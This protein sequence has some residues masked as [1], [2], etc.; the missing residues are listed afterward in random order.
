MPKQA[1]KYKLKPK[2][3][4]VYFKTIALAKEYSFEERE[5]IIRRAIYSEES[6]YKG[7]P[8]RFIITEKTMKQVK[9]KFFVK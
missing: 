3:E 4:K 8:F 7:K 5:S 1:Q 6:L 9:I 2:K